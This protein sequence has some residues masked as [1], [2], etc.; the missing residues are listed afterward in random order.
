MMETLSDGNDLMTS[1]PTCG[2]PFVVDS[3][4]GELICPHCGYV[5]SSAIDE[6]PEWKAF[7]LDEKANRVRAGAPLTLTLHDLG[8]ST[9]IG[10]EATD[11]RGKRLDPAMRATVERMRQWQRRVRTADSHERALSIVLGKINELCNS[12]ALPESVAETAAYIYRTSAKKKLAKGKSIMGMATATVYLACRKCG[13][14]RTLKEVAQAA[15]IEPRSLAK[16]FRFVVWEVEKDYLPAPHI[17]KYISKIVNL[18]NL[19]PKIEILALQLC[20][21]TQNGISDGRGPVG[22]AATYVHMSAVM[23]GQH[24]PQKEIAEIADVTEVTIRNRCRELLESFRIQQKL[25]WVDQNHEN[26]R[27]SVVP[28]SLP[29]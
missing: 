6:G 19:D 3:E 21:Q 7:E 1:C 5:V 22:L 4:R 27:V 16:C 25:M 23:L 26:V 8:L 29:R 20:R 9:S 14:S 11:S 2:G 13:V 15:G 10:E 17:E 24:L 28:G 12:M 18:G